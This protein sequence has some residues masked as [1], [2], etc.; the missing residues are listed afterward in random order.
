M[1][2]RRRSPRRPCA[3]TVIRNRRALAPSTDDVYR[4]GSLTSGHLKKRD[5]RTALLIKCG[6]TPSEIAILIGRDKATV[7]YRRN[8]IGKM[9]FDAKVDPKTT[10]NIIRLL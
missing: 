8:M 4:E 3:V 1:T 6:F 10:D 2:G 9:I 5:L 7:T